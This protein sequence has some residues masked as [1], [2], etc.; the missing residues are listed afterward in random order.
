MTTNGTVEVEGAQLGYRIEGHG[1]TCLVVGSS[2]F[3]PRAFSEDLR[4][5]LQLVFVDLRH[6]APSDPAFGPELISIETY[7][8][9]IEQVRQVLGL[10]DV[11]VIGTSLHG[12]IALEYARR[13]PEHVR[14]V[15]AR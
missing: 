5:H 2:V 10:D 6:F 13:H 15:V 8:D 12:T 7:S 1:E 9:D 3:Y 4:E 11:V 14:G